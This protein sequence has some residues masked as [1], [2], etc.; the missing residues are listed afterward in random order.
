MTGEG[1]NWVRK[2][3]DLMKRFMLAVTA[4]A[5]LA[6]P[7]A[8]LAKAPPPPKAQKCQPH[9]IAYVVSG[10]LVSGSL[11]ANSDGTYNGSLTV[12]VTKTNK[13]AKSDKGTTKAYTL[14]NA[15]VKLHGENPAVLTANSRVN[16]SGTITTLAKKCNQT[17]FTAT[18]TIKKA[19]IKPPKPP[20]H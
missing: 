13:H 5:L 16:L 8:S 4:F 11:T 10:T 20:K 1:E 14:T 18:I 15:K 17:G 12:H 6:V 9:T 7:G 19:D 3:D 2:E